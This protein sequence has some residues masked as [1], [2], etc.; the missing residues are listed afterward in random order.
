MTKAA[1]G[2]KVTATINKVAAK[3]GKNTVKP[4]VKTVVIKIAGKVVYTRGM[5]IK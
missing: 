1:V 3:I 4:G 2:A 5:T